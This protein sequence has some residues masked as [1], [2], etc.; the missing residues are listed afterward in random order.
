ASIDKKRS[1]PDFFKIVRD[2]ELVKEIASGDDIF[3]QFAQFGNFP[4]AVA[5][6]KNRAAFGFRRR[7]LERVV[8]RLVG[9]IDVQVGAQ[10]NQ[11]VAHGANDSFGER[12]RFADGP[13][14]PF[15]RVD[16]HQQQHGAVNLVV[17]AQV[18][19][20]AQR[21]P[22]PVFVPHL[23]LGLA[24]GVNDSGN[25]FRQVGQVEV[26]SQGPERTPRVGGEKV[27]LL[28]R[29]RGEAADGQVTSEQHDGQVSG[30]LEVH[31]VA[32]ELVEHQVPLGHFLVYGD[33][34]FV[35]GLQLFLRGF[36]F[37]VDALK[38]FIGG[39]D[40]FVGGLDLFVG[41]F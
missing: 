23:A 19:P 22:A 30:A 20:H 18:G 26:V 31:Q 16:I 24:P 21:I 36:Q 2:L 6:L 12:P 10:N 9:R 5:Q 7:D 34:L 8:E 41:R 15:E 25:E 13:L 37:F 40:F 14:G 17:E 38:L 4:L 32:V 11:W 35:G 28:L 3:Q 33:Q 39:S 1:E 27:E 29:L